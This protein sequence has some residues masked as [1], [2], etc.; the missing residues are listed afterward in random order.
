MTTRTLLLAGYGRMGSALMS[1]WKS[2]RPAQ[3]D[4]YLIIEPNTASTHDADYFSD[5]DQLPEGITPDIIVLAIKPQQLA[6]T[7]PAYAKRFG[8]APLY[9]SIAAGK[10]LGFYQ[11]LLGKEAR[12]V[13]VMPNTPA[14]IGE[15]MSVCCAGS[16]VTS[17]AKS[18]ASE[19]MA[20]VGEVAWLEDESLMDAVTAV[21]GSGPAYVFLF[22]DALTQGG[23][24]AGLSE[25]LAKQLALKTVQGSA[26]LAAQS[27]DS[28]TALRQNV[29]S[30]NGTTQAAIELLQQGSA[31]ENLVKQAVLRAAHRS[32]ELS[33]Q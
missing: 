27:S 12:V 3:I 7:L 19:L 21:S 16:T 23:I 15:G 11:E 5:L 4:R 2:S 9:I 25:P 31:F 28:F 26:L 17:D 33:E 10:T 30:P 22:L 20:A 24:A 14:L 13:R 1:R 6:E 18:I 8:T 29:T 32:K